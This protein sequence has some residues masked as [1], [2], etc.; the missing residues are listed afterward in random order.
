[1]GDDTYTCG[2]MLSDLHNSVWSELSDRS[3]IDPFRRNLQRG[4]LER[5]EF[6]MTEEAP[7]APA[8]FANFGFVNVDVSQ[9]DIRA[10]VRGELETIQRDA[11][12]AVSRGV[13]DNMTRLHLRD[14]VARVEDILN[15][16]D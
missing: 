3:A 1:M 4:Y 2:E 6:L 8:F 16:R 15:P 7:A 5:L 11:N 10:L 9:S 14:V 12:R 13:S